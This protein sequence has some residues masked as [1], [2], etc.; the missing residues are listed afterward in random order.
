[1]Q[2]R[3]R[4][5]SL[6]RRQA[7]LA[8]ALC[9]TL[10]P[11]SCSD[12]EPEA[13][14]TTTVTDTVEIAPPT[15]RKP[16]PSTTSTTEA[17]PKA[18]TTSTTTVPKFE[19]WPLTG[20]PLVY[21][22]P[23]AHPAMVVKLD[24]HPKARPQ[25]GLNEADI[26]FEENVES[27]T[28]FA[29]VFHS[30]RADPVGPIRSGR[31]QDVDLLGALNRPLFVWSGGNRRVTDAIVGSDLVQISPQAGG[32]FFR[33]PRPGP[34]D[35]YANMSELYALA[36]LDAAPPPPQ[37]TYRAADE[38]ADGEAV[39]GTKLSMDGVRVMWTWDSG[40]EA[41]LRA[42]DDVPHLDTVFGAQVN[43]NNVVVLFVNYRPSPADGRSP[44][45]Q[46]TGFGEA[47]VYTDGQLI[48]GAWVRPDRLSPFELQ[49]GQG[50]VI[51]LTPG[52]TFIELARVGT[53]VTV[54]AG[55][56]A[57]DVPYP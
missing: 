20:L 37:F 2:L 28:R 21:G 54:P 34:H 9:L 38:S 50:D 52:R 8:A 7:V 39:A 16:A 14:T 23:S 53:A 48:A 13:A 40:S 47:W 51:E 1:M 36:P 42:S 29:A 30:D 5:P 57:S 55:S 22:V 45:A 43:T 33:S 11:L 35:L 32:P 27:L 24:N 15:T 10:V 6:V 46:T 49:D 18:T 56:D 4:R 19:T 17:E 41:F 26:V 31:T 3:E 44:E 12:D 25:S